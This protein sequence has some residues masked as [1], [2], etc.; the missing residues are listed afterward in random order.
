MGNIVEV[1]NLVKTTVDRFGK[2][3]ILIPNAGV[4]PMKDLEGTTEQDF[5]QT[6]SLNVKGPYFLAQVCLLPP[7][8]GR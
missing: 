7:A 4:M 8:L 3:D 6:F 2:I 5:D 1:G